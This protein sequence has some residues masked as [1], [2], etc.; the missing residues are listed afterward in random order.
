MRAHIRDVYISEFGK[1]YSFVGPIPKSTLACT[2]DCEI[3]RVLLHA[4]FRR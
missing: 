2:N 3:W 4:K 1:M